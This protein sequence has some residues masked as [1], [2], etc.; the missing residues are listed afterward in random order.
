M[1]LV[2]AQMTGVT[3]PNAFNGRV[4]FALDHK[5]G[6]HSD[7]LARGYIAYPRGGYVGWE[8]SRLEVMPLTAEVFEAVRDAHWL[9]AT[10]SDEDVWA[11]LDD[12]LYH[13]RSQAE[14]AIEAAQ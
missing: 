2:T 3:N 6:P 12:C 10:P 11:V 9:D 13:F 1:F 14:T 7:D 5:E 4:E 8:A